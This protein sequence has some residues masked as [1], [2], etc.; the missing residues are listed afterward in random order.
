LGKRISAVAGFFANLT[1]LFTAIFSAA[2]LGELPH[3]Y[4]VAA[5]ALIVGGI[6]VTARQ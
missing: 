1:P 3:L 5:F 2:F 6:V 4:H